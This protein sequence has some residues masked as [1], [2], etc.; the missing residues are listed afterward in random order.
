ME[1][2]KTTTLTRILDVSAFGELPPTNAI[3][4]TLQMRSRLN[5]KHCLLPVMDCSRGM[6][7]FA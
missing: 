2:A 3:A 5:G 1:I 6:R 7:L 4:F